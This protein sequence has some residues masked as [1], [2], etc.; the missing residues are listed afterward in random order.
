MVGQEPPLLRRLRFRARPFQGQLLDAC[1]QDRNPVIKIDNGRNHRQ[2]VG[3][4][5]ILA[6]PPHAL[7]RALADGTSQQDAPEV[8]EHQL[9]VGRPS[10]VLSGGDTANVGGAGVG[11]EDPVGSPAP[12]AVK[13][14]RAQRGRPSGRH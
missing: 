7:L 12:S 11:A 3:V 1:L 14:A 2:D 6:E 9:R 8:A 13:N 10:A 4:P 5:T